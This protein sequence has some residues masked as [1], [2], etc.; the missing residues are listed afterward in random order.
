LGT[1]TG[2]KKNSYLRITEEANGEN[3]YKFNDQEHTKQLVEVI[4]MKEFYARKGI[5][6]LSVWKDSLKDETRPEENVKVGKTRL[7]VAAPFETIYLFRKYFEKFKVQ[8]QK[9][10]LFLP[11]AVGINPVSGE[12]TDLALKLLSKGDNMC[13]ADFS[14]YDT[15][16][17]ADFMKVVGEV[18]IEVIST[19]T[20]KTDDNL[21][22]EVLWHE[23]I[24]TFHLSYDMIHLVK[25][26][27][28]SGN[29]YTTVVNC[30]VNFMYHWFAYIKITGNQSLGLFHDEVAMF[31]FG[32]D[33]IYSVKHDSLFTF[34]NIEP[35][36]LYLGQKYT[37]IDKSGVTSL[38]KTLDEITFLKRR[39]K[40]SSGSTILYKAPLDTESIEQQFN[41]TYIK[42]DD[43]LTLKMQIDEALI[44]AAAHGNTYFNKFAKTLKSGVR[45]YND[46][47]GLEKRLNTFFFYS[48]YLHMLNKRMDLL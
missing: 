18:I 17:R 46:G 48:D 42:Y 8:W 7:F 19:I 5:R 30:M 28:P 12:W 15:R 36:M 27:N 37:T 39:F 43:T 32:D 33:V 3:R 34:N 10:R 22:M 4:K 25:H 1:R 24:E 16:L 6:V 41:Y 21:I 2:K 31:S 38:M 9:K 40:K 11:H 26:G 23:I 20:N 44:E 35:W 47:M 29:P 13:D 45:R 14:S